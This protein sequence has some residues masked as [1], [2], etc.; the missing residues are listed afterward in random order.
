MIEMT[1]RDVLQARACW[2]GVDRFL[3]S[4]AAAKLL[5]ADT[6]PL[7]LD[8][9]DEIL[10][11]ALTRES[12]SL[13]QEAIKTDAPV[14]YRLDIFARRYNLDQLISWELCSECTFWDLRWALAAVAKTQFGKCDELRSL[15][16]RL[17]IALFEFDSYHFIFAVDSSAKW[18]AQYLN[19][20]IQ[21]V[22][23]KSS[24][25]Q[26]VELK[27]KLRDVAM[28]VLAEEEL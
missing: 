14:K 27:T 10:W 17:N 11:V 1:L 4:P 3:R 9:D 18:T 16:D 23:V 2:G 8:A 24:A 15:D 26:R 21:K 12:L 20:N 19:K 13:R 7:R 6:E 5:I 22:L 28:A 25:A